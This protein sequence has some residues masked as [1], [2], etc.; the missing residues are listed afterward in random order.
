MFFAL[1]VFIHVH[2]ADDDFSF[3]DIAFQSG[4]K[5]IAGI[6][7]A[8]GE[9]EKKRGFLLNR[10]SYPSLVNLRN[11]PSFPSIDRLRA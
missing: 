8:V 10:L 1:K 7:S 9:K 4:G 6:A 11:M 3:F 2:D 5:D